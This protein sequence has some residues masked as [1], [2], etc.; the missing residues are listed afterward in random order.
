M[1]R[2][3]NVLLGFFNII[4]FILSVAILLVGVWLADND[5]SEC[6]KFLALLMVIIGACLM[7]FSLIGICGACSHST[8]MLVLYLILMTIVIVALVGLAGFF[9]FVLGA[10]HKSNGEIIPKEIRS[11]D[12]SNWLPKRV[13]GNWNKIKS[14]LSDMKICTSFA[15]KRTNKIV[16]KFYAKHLTSIQSGCCKP[17]SDCKFTHEGPMNWNKTNGVYKNPDCSKW[18]NTVDILCY[19]C[20]SCKAGVIDQVRGDWIGLSIANA[21]VLGL[22][23]IFYVIGC[24]ACCNDMNRKNRAYVYNPYHNPYYYRGVPGGPPGGPSGPRGPY[25]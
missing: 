13:N 7:V 10:V 23:I 16:E 18:E 19:N 17:S 25:P 11:I 1:V 20:L 3:S 22:V 14:C 2:C 4:T 6:Q 5:S 21:I 9:G 24:C 8:G 12:F 15:D